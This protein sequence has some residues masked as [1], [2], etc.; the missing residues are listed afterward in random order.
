MYELFYLNVSCCHN[1]DIAEFHLGSPTWLMHAAK[2][3]SVC[4]N[5]SVRVYATLHVYTSCTSN[6]LERCKS[7]KFGLVRG[8]LNETVGELEAF[9]FGTW[10]HTEIG[11]LGSK[12]P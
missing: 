2:L 1:C 12:Q 10:S 6:L 9:W 4:N 11:G 8:R 7:F 3:V 5:L